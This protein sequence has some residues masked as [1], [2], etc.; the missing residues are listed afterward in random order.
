MLIREYSEGKIDDCL[1]S[2]DGLNVVHF[3]SNNL[4]NIISDRLEELEKNDH[5]SW[6]YLVFNTFLYA[7]TEGQV[8][9]SFS[10]GGNRY[11]KLTASISRR[12]YY[13][14]TVYC[15]NKEAPFHIKMNKPS[16]DVPHFNALSC[17][18]I[19]IEADDITD[20]STYRLKL[21][22]CI[23]SIDKSSIESRKEEADM[24]LKEVDQLKIDIK[25]D[26]KFRFMKRPRSDGGILCSTDLNDLLR[27]ARWDYIGKNKKS[28]LISTVI[29]AS[30]RHQIISNGDFINFNDR[31]VNTFAS[32]VIGDDRAKSDGPF[33]INYFNTHMPNISFV[34]SK[35][36]LIILRYA[37]G[38]IEIALKGEVNSIKLEAAKSTNNFAVESKET[39][40]Y[41]NM[42]S[43]SFLMKDVKFN[44]PATIVFWEDGTK[45]VVKMDESEINYDPEKAIMAAYTKKALST[46][47]N[48]KERSIDLTLEKAIEK[49][50]SYVE[51][52][53]PKKKKVALKEVKI[54]K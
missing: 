39:E 14:R 54:K 44:G 1:I 25:K 13:H 9:S 32:I 34:L 26:V 27:E 18:R 50:N 37:N 45:T 38:H 53:K 8:Y 51:E 11:I 31:K 48:A 20:E 17:V 21:Y 42:H 46:L 3:Y 5:Y 47:S 7:S 16:V 24:P 10:I 28:S 22:A 40:E 12:D 29:L 19:I 23:D 15:M 35:G 2:R 49:Y 52:M 33:C 30:I 41:R 43:K 6:D 36:I 4:Y